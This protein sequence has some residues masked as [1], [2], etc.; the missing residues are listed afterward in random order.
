[1]WMES[2]PPR[3]VTPDQIVPQRSSAHGRAT[4]LAD[5]ATLEM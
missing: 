5:S 3:D 4:T 2:L 1:V